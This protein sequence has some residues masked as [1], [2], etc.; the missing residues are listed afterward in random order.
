MTHQNVKGRYQVATIYLRE[1]DTSD[2]KSLWRHILESAK[3]RGILG[4]TALHG[5][6][7]Y[8]RDG[9]VHEEIPVDLSGDLP[10]KIDICDTKE[11]ID[12]FLRLSKS[13]LKS[14]LV[15]KRTVTFHSPASKKGIHEH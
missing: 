8:G 4:A 5:C 10:L 11:S 13:F 9:H 12:E 3:A 14:T 15:L 7:G 2:G 1:S 6:M